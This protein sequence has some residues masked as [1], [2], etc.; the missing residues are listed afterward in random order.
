MTLYSL[1][2]VRRQESSKEEWESTLLINRKSINDRF[3]RVQ[4]LAQDN[5]ALFMAIQHYGKLFKFCG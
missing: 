5:E 2:T 4:L 3:E 1:F